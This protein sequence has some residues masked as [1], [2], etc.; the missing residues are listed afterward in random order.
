MYIPLASRIN[1]A[2]LRTNSAY[3]EESIHDH[4]TPTSERMGDILKLV[5]CTELQ[6]CE[7]RFETKFNAKF[8]KN[9]SN[10]NT[11]SDQLREHIGEEGSDRK[12]T[13]PQSVICMRYSHCMLNIV[14]DIMIA[15]EE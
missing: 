1:I 9:Q 5:V 8:T 14:D 15:L 13:A 3:T 4:G 11:Q 12:E 2:S 10:M 7:P 6:I